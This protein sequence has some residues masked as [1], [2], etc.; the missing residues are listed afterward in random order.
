MGALLAE[1]SL[2]QLFEVAAIV[3]EYRV[4]VDYCKLQLCRIGASKILRLPRGQYLETVRT[5]RL[6]N[7]DRHIFIEV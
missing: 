6:C 4:L 1:R 3:G 7:K 5:Q 2:V